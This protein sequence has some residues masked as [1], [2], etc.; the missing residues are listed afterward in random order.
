MQLEAG[1]DRLWRRFV[2][3][4]QD[5]FFEVLDDQVAELGDAHDHPVVLLHEAFNAGLRVFA[6]EAQQG[7]DGALMVEQQ[8]VFGAS[9]QH[10]QGVAHLPQELLGRGQQGVFALHQK[11]FAGQ[12]PQVQ[13]AVL[14]TGDPQNGLDIPQPAGRALDVGFQVVFGVVVFVMPGFLLGALGQ[15]ELL[16]RPHMRGAGDFQHALAQTLGAADG[17][18]FHQVGDHGQVGA[19]LFG[20]FS[21]RT[22]AL[23]DFQADIPQQRQKTLDGV[24][25]DLMVGAVQQDQQVDI[26]VG[27]QFATAV[28]AD[29]HQGDIGVLAPIKLLPGLLQDVIDEP[30]TILDQPANLPAAAKALVE[31]LAGL[32]DGLLEG[33]YGAGL[34][35]QFRLELATVEEFGIHLGH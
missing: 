19:G 13:G 9:G 12:G 11:T 20:A 33:C 8:A 35:R 3:G 18:A 28:A 4:G 22:H 27:V 17:A 5:Y 6:L 31:H 14:A 7:G 32:A 1:V 23:A 34:Q 2:F 29:G 30:G 16:A 25:K 21:H 26:G 15:E 10:V 24:T